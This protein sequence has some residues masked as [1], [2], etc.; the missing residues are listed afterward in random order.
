VYQTYDTQSNFKVSN[1]F[2][3][4]INGNKGG[5]RTQN[6]LISFTTMG[7]MLK[8]GE[9]EHPLD[10]EMNASGAKCI[11]L[12]LSGS[13]NVVADVR[14]EYTIALNG[15]ETCDSTISHLQGIGFLEW[16]FGFRR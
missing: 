14:G 16:L 4:A 3:N 12:R 9:P 2:L 8:N 15:T 10:F 1:D 6:Y 7:K 5:L 13:P 11:F